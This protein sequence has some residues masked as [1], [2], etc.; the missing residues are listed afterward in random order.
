M[1]NLHPFKVLGKN[2]HKSTVKGV[3]FDPA[4]KF[5]ASSGDDPAICIWRASDDWGLEARIDAS[6][7]VFKSKKR[8]KGGGGGGDN[9]D[10][11]E[12][13]DPGE[14]ASLSMFRRISFAPDGSHVGE[15]RYSS[16]DAGG[17]GAERVPSAR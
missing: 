2:V 13:D 8:K 9:N 11:E 6:S 10:E 3:S 17:V 4:G 16:R 15:T 1:H 14:L 12:E 5:I 7:G